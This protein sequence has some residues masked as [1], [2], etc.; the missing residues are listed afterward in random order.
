MAL[1]FADRVKETTTTTGTGTLSLAGAA[2]GFQSFAAIGN[3]NT[4]YYAVSSVTGSEWE[5]GL[6]T[7]SSTGPTLARTSVLAS[8]NSGSAVSF[9]AGTKDVYVV[10]PADKVATIDDIP[11]NNNELTNGAGYITGNQTIT[12]SGDATGS[13]TTSIAVTVANDSHTHDTR[14]YTETEIGNFFSGTTAIT[15][16]SK[17]N[18]DTAYGWGNHASAGYLTG[19]QT[20]TL[21][22]D[23]SGSGTTSISVTVADDSH[24][25][26]IS[27]VDG[28]QTAL[29]AKLASSSYTASDVLTKIKTVDGSGSGLDADTV[30]G[31]QASSFLRS[32]ASDS[33]SGTITLTNSADLRFQDTGGTYPTSSG[34]FQWVLNND[35]AR[36]YAQQPA[37]DYIDFFFK[38]T[39]NAGSTDRFVFWIDDYR[40]ATYDKYPAYFHGSA[41]YLAVPVDG[42]GNPNTSS[43]RLAVPYSGNVTIDG[44]KILTTADEGSGN[45]LDADTLDG[46]QGTYY[47]AA[48]TAL[49]TS[50]SFGG[51][52][53][54]TYNAIVVADDSHNH[55]I[56]NVDGLQTALDG[57]LSTTGKAADSDKLDSLDS[58]QFLRS[59][60]T[61]T[62]SGSLT[63]TGLT[64][65]SNLR[66]ADG[67][68]NDYNDYDELAAILHR[69]ESASAFRPVS[70]IEYWNGSAWTATTALNSIIPTLLTGDSQNE[71]NI[72][73]A[74]KRF[75]FTIQLS[76]TYLG[77]FWIVSERHWSGSGDISRTYDMKIE[78]GNSDMSTIN[79]TSS[80][81]VGAN[82]YGYDKLLAWHYPNQYMRVEYDCSNYVGDVPIVRFDAYNVYGR[83]S[84]GLTDNTPFNWNST[85]LNTP[86]P[87]LRLNGN[88]VWHSGNDGA[89][90][91]LDADTLDGQQGTYYQAAATALTTSTTFGGDVS[92]TYNAIVVADDSHNHII[93]NVDGLQTALDGKYSTSGGTISG[94]VTID[95]GTS[96]QLDIVCD[97]TGTAG[98]RAYG[99]S[100][101]TGYVEVGQSTAY[102]GGIFYNGDGSPAFASGETAD[103]V[104][105]YRLSAGTKTVVFDYNYNNSVV[106]FKDS[107]TVAS[108]LTVSGGDIVLGGT[109]RIQGIDTVSAG[110]DAANKTY[111]DTAIAGLGATTFPFYKSD[112][113]SDTIAITNG[114]FPFYKSNGTQDNIGVS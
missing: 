12:L 73:N 64:R 42:S 62:A 87:T 97:D 71:G 6:G 43:A 58:S 76:S 1:V 102:G 4:C 36:I 88:A 91:G 15:G 22:G 109:G 101:G 7:Y 79:A 14:Y 65:F 16:Y 40:G 37:S 96:T 70:N 18:W 19:N 82:I 75:R 49:T 30:D 108:D 2:T 52:V 27:N 26:I 31:I 99:A 92:G 98:L 81:T 59:D 69:K 61:D 39:D 106:R 25:H 55:V 57:K 17:S 45:G 105:F 100:Q 111:V 24:N 20:I 48:A 21:S 54:G 90:S 38:I 103:Y 93:S 60:A 10:Y 35:S 66:F 5:V 29:D 110:T 83:G 113:S 8:S 51:D 86:I 80:F 104:S 50:T 46:Q 56:S 13:G 44:N 84:G 67:V 112:G 68:S 34:G 32:D 47:Q 74:Y 107:I 77:G 41:A 114:S 3:G 33:A 78:L 89:G 72:P 95:N 63:F 23:V 28:L 53:S 11:T 9:S 94:N 85:T